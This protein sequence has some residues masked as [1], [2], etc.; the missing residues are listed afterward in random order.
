MEILVAWIISA[1]TILVLA[2]ILPGISISSFLTALVVALV[3]G[4]MNAFV[5]PILIILTL[6]INILTLGLFTLVINGLIIALAAYLI[7]GFEV[8]NFWWA[9]GF[10]I[11]LSLVMSLFSNL[12]KK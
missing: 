11:L 6:P 2:Y 3:L 1:L 7:P 5:K 10:A 9:I 4:L 12:Q 8:D